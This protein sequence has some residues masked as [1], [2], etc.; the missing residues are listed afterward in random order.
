MSE[1]KLAILAKLGLVALETL[2]ETYEARHDSQGAADVRAA[3]DRLGKVQTEELTNSGK[4]FARRVE[5]DPSGLGTRPA[6]Q[7]V[8][9]PMAWMSHFTSQGAT[10]RID[11]GLFSGANSAEAKARAATQITVTVK[12]GQTVRVVPANIRSVT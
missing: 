7:Y 10:A 8:G 9:D 11:R 2:R 4:L 6:L 5:L 1:T 3:I 12:P